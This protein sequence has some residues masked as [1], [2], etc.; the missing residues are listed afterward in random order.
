MGGTKTSSPSDG[1]LGNDARTGADMRGRRDVLFSDDTS[2]SGD[3]SMSNDAATDSNTAD[4][5]SDM[6]LSP[7]AEADVV[8]DPIEVFTARSLQS[9]IDDVQPMTGIVLW[10]DSWNS[11]NTKDD[12]QLEYSYYAPNK[13]IKGKNSYDWNDFDA[14]LDRVAARGNQV[15]PRFY[16]VYPGAQTTVPDY[17]KSRS[18]YDENSGSVEGKQTSFPDWTNS[19]LQ[20]ATIDFMTAV[21]NRYDNDPRIAFLQVGFGLWG[22]YHIYQG[23]NQLGVDFPSH[24]FQKRFINHLNSEFKTLHWSISVDAAYQGL[25]AFPA[26][27]SLA[28]ADFG[29]FDDSFMHQ[30]HQ[31]ENEP[32]WNFFTYKTRFLTSPHG[33]EFS[34]YTEF[35]QKNVLNPAGLHGKTFESFSKRFYISYMIGNDQPGYSFKNRIK[36]AGMATGYKFKVTKFESSQSNT[37]VEIENTGVA[38]LYYD[39]YPTVGGTRSPTSLKGLAPGSTRSF[40]VAKGTG[41]LT[42]SS[43]RLVQGQTIQFDANL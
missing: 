22:E 36:A 6:G 31:Q 17:I 2:S 12:V 18:D 5:S 9:T 1:G 21:A 28:N 29:L 8:V 23:P 15:I 42:I 13:I 39:A 32:N 30:S 43:D 26:D 24:A 14:L 27:Q 19:E 34:Y 11:G 38:T 37:R 40:L 4:L 35:D 41:D 25:S 3:Q 16:Y 10:A 7:D 20:D 33:G